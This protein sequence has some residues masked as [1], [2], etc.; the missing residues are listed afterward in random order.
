MYNITVVGSTLRK[1]L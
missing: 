1:T